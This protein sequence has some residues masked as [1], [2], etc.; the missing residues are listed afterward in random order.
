MY[1]YDV[2]SV[3]VH[4]NGFFVCICHVLVYTHDIV[5]FYTSTVI[6]VRIIM[7]TTHLSCRLRGVIV[8]ENLKC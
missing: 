3:I 1:M 2:Q 4:K 6:S 8:R 5:Q 7:L